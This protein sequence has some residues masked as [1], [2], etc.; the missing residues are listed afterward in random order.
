MKILIIGGSGNISWHCVKK[1]SEAGHDIWVLN[2]RC[3]LK[4]RRSIDDFKV[5][6]VKAD[7]R[8]VENIRKVMENEYWDV[9]IDFICYNAED[10][11]RDILIFKTKVKQF[12]FISSGANYDRAKI[13]YP[14][15]EDALLGTRNWEYVKG[16]IECEKIFMKEW[17]ESGFPVTIIRPGHTYDTLIPEAVGNG[18]WTN[19]RRMAEG[20]PIV[21]HGDG[22]NLWTITHGSDMANA[23]EALLGNEETFGEAYHITSDEHINWIEITRFISNA[24]GVRNP[25]MVFFPSIKIL[26]EDFSLGIGIVSHKMWPDLYDN[27][28][29]KSIAKGWSTK[30]DAEKGINE[31]IKWLQENSERQRVNDRLNTV[32]DSLCKQY[33]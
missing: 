17:K 9:V 23:M 13:N 18:D 22:T 32:L 3:T 14:I 12:I 21:I 25:K 11:Y 8:D 31:S 28:K 27:S 33:R 1:F 26:E 2:R 10:A 29:I 16:K 30:V 7:I 15:T 24:L 19:A 6:I 5:H 20:K 4:T